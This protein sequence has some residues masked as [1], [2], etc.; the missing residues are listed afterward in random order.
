M[1]D[2]RLKFASPITKKNILKITPEVC[3]TCEK[4]SYQKVNA[5][6]QGEKCSKCEG[7]VTMLELK[8]TG[9][10]VDAVISIE[11]PGKKAKDGDIV[12]YEDTI[13]PNDSFEFFGGW[14]DKTMGSEITVY[15]NGV[16]NTKFKTS[17]GVEKIG[18]GLSQGDF[19]VI[20]GYSRNGGLLCKVD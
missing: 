11:Q 9:D 5:S 15:V 8:Y 1:D 2:M 4:L 10:I 16:E 3:E 17:C 20:K 13:Q 6:C 19:E 14:K 12:I 18:P 7:Q